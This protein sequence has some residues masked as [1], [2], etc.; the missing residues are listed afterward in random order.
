MIHPWKISPD[1]E[2]RATVAASDAQM[3]AQYRV[4]DAELLLERAQAAL[5][6]ATSTF[7]AVEKA[8]CERIEAEA[9]GPTP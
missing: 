7:Y 4:R 1:P 2:T 3:S 5:Q 8:E 6:I 9:A